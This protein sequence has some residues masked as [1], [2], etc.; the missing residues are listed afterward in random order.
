MTGH[1]AFAGVVSGKRGS[2]VAPE[3][4]QTILELDNA[5]LVVMQRFQRSRIP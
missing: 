5:G 4:R 3:V 1:R 2:R